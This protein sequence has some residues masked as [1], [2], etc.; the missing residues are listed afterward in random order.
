MTTQ[1]KMMEIADILEMEVSEL[2]E[3]MVLSDIETWD[4]MAILSIIAVI[5]DRFNKFPNASEIRSYKTIRDLMDA[6]S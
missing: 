6:M 3:D 1:E 5:N 2:S 4:S